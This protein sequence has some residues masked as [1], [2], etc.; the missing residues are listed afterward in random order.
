MKWTN[1]S[2]Q[3]SLSSY[4]WQI[5]FPVL[6]LIYIFNGSLMVL[7]TSLHLSYISFFSNLIATE[8][9]FQACLYLPRLPLFASSIYTFSC[10][11]C[12]ELF[13]QKNCY[14]KCE[15]NEGF[16]S[17]LLL[18]AQNFRGT[19]NFQTLKSCGGLDG[20]TLTN[21]STL[22]FNNVFISFLFLILFWVDDK[23]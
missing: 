14:R 12:P 15:K 11:K 7:L 18:I 5:Y 8:K 2:S 10:L 17:I 3:S 13:V 4:W 20:F 6:F 9:K 1:F 23:V 19:N 16:F 21:A 22:A